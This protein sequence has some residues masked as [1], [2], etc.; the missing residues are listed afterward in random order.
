MTHLVILQRDHG[1]ILDVE[2]HPGVG[3]CVAV[4]LVA[5]HSHDHLEAS[6][7]CVWG[8][9][10]TEYRVQSEPGGTELQTAARKSNRSVP[11]NRA[12]HS[13]QKSAWI[14]EDCVEPAQLQRG[15]TTLL[16]PGA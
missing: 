16:G 14:R 1:V 13:V 2:L 15:L 4:L 7:V 3:I 11:R 9:G 8:G 5:H 10:G 6:S 12:K